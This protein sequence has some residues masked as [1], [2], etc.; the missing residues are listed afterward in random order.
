MHTR[1]GS[2][3]NQVIF[4]LAPVRLSGPRVSAARWDE[5]DPPANRERRI[6]VDDSE[7][8]GDRRAYLAAR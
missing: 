2:D 5:Q 6:G 1:I 8:R 4:F 3:I 7:H